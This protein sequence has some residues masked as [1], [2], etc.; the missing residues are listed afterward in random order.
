LKPATIAIDGPSGS[1]KST[2]GELLAKRLGYL[3]F[4]TGVMYRAVT[5]AALQRGL[6]VADEGQISQL[7][8]RLQIEVLPATVT[9]GRQNT[10]LADGVDITDRLRGTEI[11]ANV[12]T[13]AS[14]AR[15]RA[16]MV[17]QQRAI[18]ERGRVVMIGRDIGTVV[19][20]HSELKVYLTASVEERAR[21][22]QRENAQRGDGSSYA[23][24]LRMMR[25]RDE[26]D[27]GRENSPLRP[28]PEA[29]LVDSERLPA[30]EIVDSI[31][32]LWK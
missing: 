12:S 1:G 28:A 32:Q 27:M 9:D 13:V 25:R 3:Y 15:V 24:V 31:E 20:P 2:V 22:R 10:V 4:D 14:Y 29:H 18:G 16:A 23:D 30:A 5:C 19:L 7:A 8:E 6:N 11:D 26:L 21:R 17:R